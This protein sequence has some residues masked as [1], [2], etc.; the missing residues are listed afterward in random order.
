MSLAARISI[1]AAATA[2]AAWG[3]K[4]LV[5]GLAGGLDRS[6]LESPL[7]GVGLVANVVAYVA[8]GV[9]VTTG[10]PPGWRLLGAVGAI[11][12]GVAVSLILDV[13]VE[14]VVP[15]STGWVSGEAGLWV[16]ALVTLLIC[17]A[18]AQRAP[19]RPEA[20]PTGGRSAN[21]AG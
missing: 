13:A 3:F 4:A 2:A 1:A 10:R 6:A 15:D 17:L 11:V 19:R 18:A 12:L 5:I 20:S 14:L 16:T 8:L 7:F 21:R 9:A